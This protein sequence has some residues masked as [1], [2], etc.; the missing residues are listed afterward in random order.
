MKNNFLKD[1]SIIL[2]SYR[3]KKNIKKT[4]PLIDK[5]ISIILVENSMDRSIKTEFEKKYK[6]LKVIIPKS[7]SGQ[8]AAF[9]LGAKKSKKKYLLFMDI[10]IHIKKSQI[11]TLMRIA[12]KIRVFGVL[13]PEIKNHNYKES[14][15]KKINKNLFQI[16][17]NHGCVMLVKKSI[18][19]KV[20]YFDDNI[21]LY[22]EESDLYTRCIEA[23]LPVYMYNKVKISNPI[24]KSIDRKYLN[25]YIVVRNWHY[26]WSKFYYYKKHYGYITGILK[27]A[28]NLIRAIKNIFFSFVKFEFFKTKYFLAEIS[29]LFSSYLNFKSYYRLKD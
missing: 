9:N 5:N 19:K 17:F 12:K 7:N 13:T 28:P 18:F 29:G 15:V 16:S 22:F 23:N 24:S 3:S 25:E 1:L 20:K 8:G 6:N 11:I 26:C 14:I 10:D 27:T 21:F 4:I 2:V